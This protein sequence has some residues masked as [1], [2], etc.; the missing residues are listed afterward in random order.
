M[1]KKDYFDVKE[2]IFADI[3]DIQ[4]INL[5]PGV[6]EGAISLLENNN[7]R[8]LDALHVSCALAWNAE[9]FLSSDKRQI[10]AAQNSGLEVRYIS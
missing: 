7:L 9:L 1:S 8:S 6:V 3:Q 5:V 2:Q 10:E 4:I